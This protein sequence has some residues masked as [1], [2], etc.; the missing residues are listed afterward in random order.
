MASTPGVVVSKSDIRTVDLF[1]YSDRM[2]FVRGFDSV[3]DEKGRASVPAI[4]AG[5]APAPPNQ[6]R[7]R[8]ALTRLRN[9]KGA[10]SW[11]LVTKRETPVLPCI[12]AAVMSVGST[13]KPQLI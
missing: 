3:M 7:A 5:A 6:L 9:R 10:P 13:Q 12:R 2:H 11:I 4:D 8:S 1:V